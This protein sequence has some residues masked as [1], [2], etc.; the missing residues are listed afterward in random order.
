MMR[1]VLGVAGAAVLA[2][3]AVAGV[4][5]WRT[6]S[7]GAGAAAAET[8]S[9][10]EP[11][12]VDVGRA[13]EALGEAI[14][15]QTVSTGAG[16]LSPDAA[17]PWFGL[18]G[19]LEARYPEVFAKVTKE[20]LAGQ[21]LLLTWQGSDA[22]LQPIVLM[23]HQDVVPI[24]PGT[25]A[26]W[27]HGPF[28]GVVANGYIWGRGAMDDKGS[29][30][31]LMESASALVKSGWT[32]KRTVIFLFGHD[33]EVGG[34]GAQ[35]AFAVLKARGVDPAMV[36]DEGFAAIETFPITG[37]PAALIGIAEKGYISL[38]LTA[39][40]AGGHS[41]QPPRDS[42]AIRI[43]RALLALENNQ[44]PDHLDAPSMAGMVEAVAA[45]MPFTAK[46]AFAN[47]WLFRPM[48][49]E[50]LKDGAAGAMVRT[51]T[52]PTMLNGSIKDN[53]LP[54]RASAVVN[55]RIHPSDSVAAVKEHVA[56][57]TAGIEGLTIEEYEDGIASEPSPV[58]STT[59]DAWKVLSAVA[60][61][62]GGG[63]PVAPALVIG[64][65][66]A[67]FASAV[68]KDAIYRFAPAVYSDEDLTVFHGTNE[69][70]S[71]ANLGRMIRGYSQIMLAMCS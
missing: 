33:E 70:L 50:Q 30:I 23:A 35:A 14:R 16:A 4:V 63:A 41:S 57:A 13:A 6:N 24:N 26:D 45:D 18:H 34:T 37:K 7:F 27:T 51:T 47:Q 31:A 9:L 59:N 48:I 5:V 32:P 69:K 62:V 15:F 52:A 40:T 67:R 21:T 12:A 17:Q 64:A 54:Q 43:S 44:M 29:L 71:V 60:A 28:G 58:S 22:S 36:L 3:A 39:T 38:Q 2:V 66:D 25:D 19:F 46:M 53:V 20:A 56:Q 61:D 11:P 8:M 68:S 55:F 49:L 10:P 65:T 1:W 42:G